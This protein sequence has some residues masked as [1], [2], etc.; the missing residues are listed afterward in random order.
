M[1]REE[2]VAIAEVQLLRRQCADAL[3]REQMCIRDRAL[4]CGICTGLGFQDNTKA[5][6]MTRAM[7]ELTLSLIHISREMAEPRWGL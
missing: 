6:L 3:L 2:A 4:S 1:I 5:L 7:A